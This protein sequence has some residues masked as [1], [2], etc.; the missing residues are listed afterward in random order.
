M[1]QH[2]LVPQCS[3]SLV[4]L[5]QDPINNYLFK[6]WSCNLLQNFSFYL[7]FHPWA[8]KSITH[9]CVETNKYVSQ[10]KK[11]ACFPS[12]QLL[13]CLLYWR[14]LIIDICQSSA[15][16]GAVLSF[17]LKT[18]EY[19]QLCS[20]LWFKLACL[21]VKVKGAKWILYTQGIFTNC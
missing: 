8:L 18:I 16:A 13:L 5:I 6:S 11:K 9:V 15:S 21:I 10:W 2:L 1:N 4:T 12:L 7:R 17:E 14:V 19:C 3:C 20:Y